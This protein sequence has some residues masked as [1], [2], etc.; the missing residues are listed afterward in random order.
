MFIGWIILGIVSCLYGG[1]VLSANSGT[2]FYMVWFF[3]G[4]V[5]FLCAKAARSHWLKKIPQRL[6]WLFYVILC[7]GLTVFVLVEGLILS[8]FKDAGEEDLDYLIV[9]GAQM[10]DNGPSLVLRYRLDAAY[11]YL[12]E[13]ENTLCIVSGGQ[14]PNESAAEASG[15]REYL[16][17]KGISEER[18]LMEEESKDTFE[19]MLNSARLLDKEQ[20]RVGI[21]TNNFHM[22]RALS[23][24]KKQGFRHV[25]GL[26]AGS[27]KPYLP[28]NMLREFMGVVK[29]VLCGNMDLWT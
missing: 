14:G 29:D 28:N 9:L 18:I 5:C 17:K 21:V 25:C 13:H 7:V 20:D 16:L 2:R 3:L 23:L 27:T 15:M 12:I 8:H 1:F 19:N 10:R 26:A 22:Y 6:R 11:D 4:A 24:A